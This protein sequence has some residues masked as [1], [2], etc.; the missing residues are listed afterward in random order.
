MASIPRLTVPGSSVMHAHAIASLAFLLLAACSNAPPE[1]GVRGLDCTLVLL[2]TGPRTEPMSREQQNEVF[3]G[4]F[5][6]MERLAKEG[7]LLVAGPYGKQKSDPSL[8]G[9]FVLDTGD[10]DAARALAETDPGFTS[11]VFRFEYHALTTAAPLRECSAADL[12]A[13]EAI[14][15][16]GRTPQPGEGGR[17]YVLLTADGR[18]AHEALT[19]LPG[20]LLLARLDRTRTFALL[21]A[22]DLD[23]AA[24]L[25]A[26]CELRLGSYTLDEWFGSGKLAEL[27]TMAATGD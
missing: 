17:S 5:A 2:K 11:R 20:V 8:R 3:R 27:P 12:A 16:S 25:L 18:E 13:R 9:I 1:R 23:A 22:K 19:D 4:H 24:P 6:N 15:A 7:R 26:P 10:R 14:R 21:D